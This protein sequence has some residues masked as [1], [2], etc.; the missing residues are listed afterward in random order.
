MSTTIDAPETSDN[1]IQ[2]TLQDLPLELARHLTITLGHDPTD[3]Q[4]K[5]VYRALAIAVRD[6]LV[7]PWQNTWKEMQ[8]SDDRKVYYLSL[9]FLIGRSLTNAVQNLNLDGDVCDALSQYGSVL[10]DVAEQELDA[11]LGNGGLG[12]LAAC[13]LDSCA[14]LKLPVVGYGIRYEYGMFHQHIEGGRQVEDPDH[15]LKDGNP[16]EIERAEDSRR[17]RFYGRTEFYHDAEGRMRPRLVDT[18]DV[19]AVPFDMPI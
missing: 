12:R 7:G 4:K 6:R 18:R 8:R 13:F 17:I 2:S 5:Y 14:N 16:W 10:E 3:A 19:I 15:W 11:G 1:I 9:E